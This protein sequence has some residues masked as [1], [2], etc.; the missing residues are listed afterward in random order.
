MSFAQTGKASFAGRCG[1]NVGHI[2]LEFNRH[3]GRVYSRVGRRGS[4][5]WSTK[6]NLGKYTME[7]TF[8]EN[9]INE[10]LTCMSDRR[11]SCVSD[12]GL[13]VFSKVVVGYVVVGPVM[14]CY[15]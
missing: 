3:R 2:F 14:L 12:C 7:N 4:E 9:S 11:S 1:Y 8:N 10:N 6:Y 15:S 5:G 13:A